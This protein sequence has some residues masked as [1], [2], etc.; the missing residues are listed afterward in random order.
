MSDKDQ[1]LQIIQRISDDELRML[2]VAWRYGEEHPEKTPE[3]CVSWAKAHEE[4][5]RAE[6]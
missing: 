3:K 1:L 4:K 2:L 5:W 6:P